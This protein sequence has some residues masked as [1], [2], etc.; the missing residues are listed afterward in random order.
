MVDASL[1]L[2]LAHASFLCSVC[3]FGTTTLQHVSR[4]TV[5]EPNCGTLHKQQRPYLWLGRI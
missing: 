1:V 2:L 4:G 3:V 5:E